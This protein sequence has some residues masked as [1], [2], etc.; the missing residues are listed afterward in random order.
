[1]EERKL[2][3]RA[4]ELPLAKALARDHPAMR[5]GAISDAWRRWCPLS[6]AVLSTAR[7]AESQHLDIHFHIS[8]QDVAAK[9]I[10]IIRVP[11]PIHAIRD[12]IS[13]PPQRLHHPLDMIGV[14]SRLRC[15][16]SRQA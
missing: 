11:D 1:M 6:L 13:K 8:R 16:H 7:V 9:S 15:S 12:R 2:E 10:P 3:T 5:L 4:S 14:G